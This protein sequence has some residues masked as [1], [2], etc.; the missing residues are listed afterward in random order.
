MMEPGVDEHLWASR[1]EALEE[2]IRAAP[3]EALSDL[4]ELVAE[5]MEARGIPLA[6]PDGAQATE[7]ETIRQFAEARRVT[8]QIDDGEPYD[9]G[10][11]ANAVDAYAS[12]YDYL[13]NLGPT[14]GSPA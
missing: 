12:L 10:D 1:Y 3:A 8:R 7:P 4:D 11:V 13:L 9:P 14:A 2:E 6:E 5:M